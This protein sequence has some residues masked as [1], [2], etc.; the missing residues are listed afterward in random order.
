MK[1]PNEKFFEEYGLFSD[2][3]SQLSQSQFVFIRHGESEFNKFAKD[4]RKE[5][6]AKGMD[7]NERLPKER[8]HFSDT[9]KYPFLID[10]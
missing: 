10:A 3:K 9:K 4:V 1:Y 6:Q 8:E 2:S 7:E 5:I